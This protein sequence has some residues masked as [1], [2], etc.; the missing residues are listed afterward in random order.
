MRRA[1]IVLLVTACAAALGLATL[2]LAR[3][4]PRAWL[5]AFMLCMAA[6]GLLLLAVRGVRAGR[7]Q[8]RA[9]AGEPPAGP[10]A[11]TS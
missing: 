8:V 4:G 2:T 7:V 11:P 10:D 3:F 9:D 1:A 6:A 5:V